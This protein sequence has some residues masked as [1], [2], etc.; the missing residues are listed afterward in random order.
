MQAILGQ[1]EHLLDVS[2]L[3]LSVPHPRVPHVSLWHGF[4]DELSAQSTEQSERQ[5]VLRVE[6]LGFLMPVTILRL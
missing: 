2:N 3:S 5:I 1:Y 4:L 6:V